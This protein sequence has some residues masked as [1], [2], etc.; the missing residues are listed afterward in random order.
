MNQLMSNFFKSP[1]F[2]I[3]ITYVLILCFSTSALSEE[4]QSSPENNLFTRGEAL[5]KKAKPNSPDQ[6]NALA[7]ITKSADQGNVDAQVKLGEIYLN[8]KKIKTD[9]KKSFYWYKKA[10][11]QNNLTAQKKVA[12]MNKKGI[13]T[14]INM[15]QAIYW[16]RQASEQGDANSQLQLALAYSFGDGIKKNYEFAYA[17]ASVSA[18][19]GSKHAKDL[20]RILVKNHLSQE[21]LI[22]AQKL[23]EQWIQTYKKGA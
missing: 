4:K 19:S 21:A 14:D 20:Q 8:G 1:L 3:R 12:L 6:H 18:E 16:W 23:A 22:R 15:K 5:Y 17:W 7:M 10:A 2:Y 13:G 11:E 9:T